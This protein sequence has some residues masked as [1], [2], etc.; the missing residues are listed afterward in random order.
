MCERYSWENDLNSVVE[1]CQ[2]NIELNPSF[3][4]THYLLGSAYLKQRRND[5]ATA[6]FQKAVEL[7]GRAIQWLSP[8]GYCFAVTGRRAEALG[9]LKEIEEKYARREALG[10]HLAR[11]YVGLGE[12]DQAFAWFEKD[13]QQ[14][15]GLLQAIT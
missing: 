7:S 12:K 1:Q 4:G 13:F 11:V 9:I 10:Q 8:L 5:E 6:E 3:P 2:R 15:G 14:C